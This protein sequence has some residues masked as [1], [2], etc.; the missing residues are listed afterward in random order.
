M[1]RASPAFRATLLDCDRALEARLGW[2]V[3]DVIAGGHPERE[4]AAVGEVQPVLFALQVALASLW[5]SWV[6]GSQIPIRNGAVAITKAMSHARG[7]HGLRTMTIATVAAIS[8][9]IMS[10]TIRAGNA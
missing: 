5:R 2:S 6:C 1:L 4:L 3:A 10:T 9:C 8:A 7:D